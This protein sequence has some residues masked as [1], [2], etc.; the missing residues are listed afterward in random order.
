MCPNHLT[1]QD[2]ANG[3]AYCSEDCH[4]DSELEG[5][6][7]LDDPEALEAEEQQRLESDES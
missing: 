5:S 6:S 3:Y 2:V 1:A 7:L 4:L